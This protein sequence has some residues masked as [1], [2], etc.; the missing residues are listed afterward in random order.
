[1]HILASSSAKHVSNAPDAKKKDDE[2][3]DDYGNEIE[4]DETQ[5]KHDNTD[6]KGA[7][8]FLVRE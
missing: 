3:E 6:L 1:M 8:N 2:D 5:S 4:D 7:Y